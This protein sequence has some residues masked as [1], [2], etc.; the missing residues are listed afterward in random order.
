MTNLKEAQKKDKL[1]QFIKEREKEEQSGDK[2]RFDKALKSMTNEKSKP[3]QE[4]SAQDFS[5]S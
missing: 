2:E 1:E 4:T 3:D 5:D